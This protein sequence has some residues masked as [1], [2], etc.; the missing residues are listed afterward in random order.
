M[1]IDE[2]KP[3][4]TL[5]APS[6][7]KKLVS[8]TPPVTPLKRVAKTP[9]RVDA[10]RLVRTDALDSDRGGSGTTTASD[11]ALFSETFTTGTGIVFSRMQSVVFLTLLGNLSGKHSQG[12]LGQFL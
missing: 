11:N 8:K 7:S 6:S 2:S 9:S 3:I 12:V 1:G 4:S 5:V 10:R